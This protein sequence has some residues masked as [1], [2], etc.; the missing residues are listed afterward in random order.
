[1]NTNVTIRIKFNSKVTQESAVK[2]AKEIKDRIEELDQSSDNEYIDNI[3]IEQIYR[4]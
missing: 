1:M 4:N 3:Y 2:L